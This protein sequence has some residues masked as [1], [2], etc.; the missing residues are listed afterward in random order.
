MISLLILAVTAV[1]SSRAVFAFFHDPEGP[2]LIVVIGL[3]AFIYL[4]C[5]V[6]YLSNAVRML[7]SLRRLL[8][9]IFIQIIGAIGFYLIMR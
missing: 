1:A 6:F 2:N 9:A 7:T 4:L 3:A 8:F 5:L